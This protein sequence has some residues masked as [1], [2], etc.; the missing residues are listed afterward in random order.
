M[1]REDDGN[2]LELEN[3]IILSSYSSCVDLLILEANVPDIT[4][5][6]YDNNNFF[7]VNATLL[8]INN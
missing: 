6:V 8:F 3:Q 4:Y 7:K 5:L 1:Y 2:R